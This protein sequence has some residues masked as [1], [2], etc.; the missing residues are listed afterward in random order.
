M[1]LKFAS[2]TFLFLHV[3]EFMSTYLMQIYYG[4]PLVTG[5]DVKTLLE[6]FAGR[7]TAPLALNP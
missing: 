4:W 5:G 7:A 3:S 1:T 2:A 6:R